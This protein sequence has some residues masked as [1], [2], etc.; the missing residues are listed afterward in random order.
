MGIFEVNNKNTLYKNSTN[1]FVV[2]VASRCNLACSYCYMYFKEDQLWRKQPKFISR[3]TVIHFSLRLKEHLERNPREKIMICLHG[4]EPLLYPDLDFFLQIIT[5]TIGKDNVVFSIQTN[6]TIIDE[7][8]INL[9]HKYNVKIGVSMDGIKAIH[10]KTRVTH[11]GM[12]T[13]D[14]IISNIEKLRLKVPNL[15]G[16]VLQ[17]INPQIDPKEM[18]DTLE[19]YR[20]P[21]SDLLFPDLN[22]DTKDNRNKGQESIG[23]WLIEVFDLWSERNE[24]VH[25]RLFSTIIQLL[26]GVEEG[27]D[28]LGAYSK[29]VLMIETD[30][31]YH[32]YDGLK[33]S[34]EGAGHLNY[35]VSD[36]PIHYAEKTTLAIA[37]RE[38]ASMACEKCLSCNLFAVCGGGNVLQRYSKENGFDNPSV[39]CTDLMMII[40]HIKTFLEL[41]T[42]NLRLVC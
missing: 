19:S 32:I 31:T 22:H 10:D 23:Q 7:K 5:E 29:G 39:Y 2:K 16:S 36:Y 3:E 26:L 24:T 27:T 34:Y 40:N 20:I 30:G 9:L 38:K 14:S 17:V 8:R 1:I 37:Y 28:L 35:G 13:Y 15:L 41:K 6:G 21:R 33:T 12:G 25:I 42:T 4:G 11:D 18:L